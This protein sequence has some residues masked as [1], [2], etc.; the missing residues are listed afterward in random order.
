MAPIGQ[1]QPIMV[2]PGVMWNPMGRQCEIN[3]CKAEAYQIC[4]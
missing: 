2:W 4:N 1:G 3:D